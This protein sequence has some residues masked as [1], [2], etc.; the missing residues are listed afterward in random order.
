M[1]ERFNGRIS[2]VLATHRF[3][4]GEELAA[5]LERYAWLYNHHLPQKALE[6]ISPVEAM[7]RWQPSHPN[8]FHKKVINQPGPDTYQRGHDS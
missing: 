7:K 1:V 3:H 2:E 8:L 6:H 4:S 5:T